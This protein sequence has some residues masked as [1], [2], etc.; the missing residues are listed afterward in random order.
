MSSET[1]SKQ[2]T[3]PSSEPSSEPPSEPVVVPSSENP[4]PLRAENVVPRP[5][6]KRPRDPDQTQKSEWSQD[7]FDDSEWP[8]REP[9]ERERKFLRK[10]NN[11]LFGERLRKKM[12]CDGCGNKVYHIICG[13]DCQEYCK[14]CHRER[15]V[16]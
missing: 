12:T 13:P 7:D 9:T 15:R 1:T 6:R 10:L 4:M 8:R 14:K 11:E 5:C 3:V 2:G 16:D